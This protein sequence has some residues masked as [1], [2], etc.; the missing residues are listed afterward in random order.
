[1]FFHI[2]DKNQFSKKA[3]QIRFIPETNKFFPLH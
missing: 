1:M 2:S 3:E